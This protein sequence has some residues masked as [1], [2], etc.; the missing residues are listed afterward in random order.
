MDNNI[1]QD[2]F[3]DGKNLALRF[4]TEYHNGLRNLEDTVALLR[5][6]GLKHYAD[7]VEKEFKALGFE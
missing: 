4:M 2:I 5:D 6:N 3:N 7:H 1:M